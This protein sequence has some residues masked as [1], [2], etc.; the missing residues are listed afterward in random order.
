[1]GV[2][3]VILAFGFTLGALAI[4]FLA[5]AIAFS[6][7]DPTDSDFLNDPSYNQYVVRVFYLRWTA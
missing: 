6:A 4:A 7:T 3:K 5:I 2:R 1:L